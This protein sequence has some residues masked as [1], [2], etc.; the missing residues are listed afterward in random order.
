MLKRAR[1][2]GMRFYAVIFGN[3][4][5][6]RRIGVKIGTGCRI[7]TRRFG[8]EPFLIEIGDRV[9]LSRDV[10]FFTHDGS[11]WLIRDES[12]RRQR[13]GRITIGSEVFVGA[14]TILLPGVEIG[15]RVVIGAGS[16]IARSVPSGVVVAGNP[17]RV[18]GTFDD[19]RARRLADCAAQSALPDPADVIGH[20]TA[21]LIPPQPPMPL[22][23]EIAEKLAHSPQNSRATW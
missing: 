14:Y 16:V 17:A 22:P 10:A 9:T 21:A 6:A 12:G 19:L 2:L 20:A 4:R 23:K 11:T 7:L 18:L 15:D 13:F 8:S 1:R 3:E 5:Y